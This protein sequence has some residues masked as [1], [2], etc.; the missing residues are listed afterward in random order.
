[1]KKINFSKYKDIFRNIKKSWRFVKEEKRRLFICL[2]FSVLL[3]G[4]SVLAPIFSAKM[5]LSITDG[6]YMTLLAV[7]LFV[8]F[9][10][11]LRGVLHYAY[12]TEKLTIRPVIIISR[13]ALD[14]L[15]VLEGKF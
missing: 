12:N 4:M 7:A 6:L 11:I 15:R 5:L 13:D 10:E 14:R 9:L 2:F 8:L 3:C 1:M